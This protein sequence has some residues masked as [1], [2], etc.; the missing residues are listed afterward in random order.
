MSISN[1]KLHLIKDNNNNNNDYSKSLVKYLRDTN[2]L[3]KIKH[4]CKHPESD[5]NKIPS[6]TYT[7]NNTE[8][9]LQDYY[10]INEILNEIVD[11]TYNTAVIYNEMME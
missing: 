5:V 10:K 1:I 7:K 9:I 6:I 11:T 2:N 3:T 8:Y 4:T